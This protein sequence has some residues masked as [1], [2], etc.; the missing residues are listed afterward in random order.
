MGRKWKCLVY[1]VSFRLLFYQTGTFTTA[2]LDEEL[3]N[4]N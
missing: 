4:K 2:F 3:R 1:G